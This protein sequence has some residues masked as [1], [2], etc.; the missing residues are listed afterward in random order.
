MALRLDPLTGGALFATQFGS[1]ALEDRLSLAYTG[2]RL[3]GV[4]TFQDSVEAFGGEADRYRWHRYRHLPRR[5][6]IAL[7]GAEPLEQLDLCGSRSRPLRDLGQPARELRIIDLAR[8]ALVGSAF[9]RWNGASMAFPGPHLA[10]QPRRDLLL[11]LEDRHEVHC[12]VARG[13]AGERRGDSPWLSAVNRNAAR[14]ASTMTASTRAP[15]RA[16]SMRPISEAGIADGDVTRDR[17]VAAASEIDP[18]ALEPRDHPGPLAHDP[19]QLAAHALREPPEAGAL[20][21]GE[22]D[23]RPL[24]GARARAGTCG[25]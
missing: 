20:R 11:R 7:R 24:P 14:S 6:L 13:G 9:R 23:Q 8:Q 4:G 22:R 5:L 16:S 18:V 2:D 12:R 19:V 21:R 25:C 17:R 10:V 3:T 1:A 15:E